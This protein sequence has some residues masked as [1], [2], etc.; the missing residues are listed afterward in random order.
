M[1]YVLGE[2]FWLGVIVLCIALLPF[3]LVIGVT[4][5]VLGI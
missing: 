5:R 1:R 4:R 2:V 3:A